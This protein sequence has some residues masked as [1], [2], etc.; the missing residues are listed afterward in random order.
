MHRYA[1]P[2]PAA[3]SR[4]Q[5]DAACPTFLHAPSESYL[6]PSP[7]AVSQ[8]PHDLQK[9][10]PAG[11]CHIVLPVHSHQPPS[12][13]ATSQSLRNLHKMPPVVHCCSIL[14]VHSHQPPSPTATSQ[15]AS[16][17]GYEGIVMLLLEKEADVN[18][19]GGYYGNAL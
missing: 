11:R 4:L 15:S 2:F 8:L 10:L 17:G 13:T 3:A 7:T 14:S 1:P 16:C 19:Q 5:K 12:P 6:L 9:T 18:A